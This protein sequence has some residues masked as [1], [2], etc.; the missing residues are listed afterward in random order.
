MIDSI[1]AKNV[2]YETKH[3]IVFFILSIF[4]LKIMSLTQFLHIAA[5]AVAVCSCSC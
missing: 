1:I 2:S 3:N 5:A 4:Y